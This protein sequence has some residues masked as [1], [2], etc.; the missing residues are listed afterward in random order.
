MNRRMLALALVLLAPAAC[1]PPE[2][3]PLATRA[4]LAGPVA[5]DSARVVGDLRFLS[6]P[7]LL[8]R[9][10]GTPGS[11]AARAYVEEQFRQAGLR[12]F[13]GGFAQPFAFVARGETAERQG[14][15]VVGWL[16]GTERPDRFIVVTAHYDHLGVRDGQVYPGADDNASGTAALLELARQLAASPPR[17]SVIF[18]ALDAEE[19]GLRGA[20][21]FVA[22]PPVAREAM[23]LNVNMDMVSRNEA[24]ELYAVGTYHYPFLAPLVERV[25]GRSALHVRMGHDRPDLPPGDDWTLLSDHGAFHEVGIP[26]LYFGVEDHPDYHR[27]TDVFEN[28]DPAFFVRAVATVLDLVREADRELDAIEAAAGVAA[29]A[30]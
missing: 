30:G 15:N 6:D 9:A 10:T 5:V 14:V 26:F 12:A 25:D 13:E 11:A 29:A 19:L 7:A 23:V 1:A 21:A 8:G 22:S 3:A 18:A 27:P 16:Q 4:A 2:T 20:R 24:G 28:I 17:N